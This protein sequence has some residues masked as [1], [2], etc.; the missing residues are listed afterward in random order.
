MQSFQLKA[1]VESVTHRNVQV[2]RETALMHSGG[3]WPAAA[4]VLYCH[5]VAC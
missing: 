2:R 1:S 4:W 5:L 3:A